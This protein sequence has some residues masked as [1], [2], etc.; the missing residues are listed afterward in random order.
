MSLDRFHTAMIGAAGTLGTFTLAHLN[1]AIGIVAGLLTVAYL[2]RQ[3][4]RFSRDRKGK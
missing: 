3:H 4:A 1:D 2:V